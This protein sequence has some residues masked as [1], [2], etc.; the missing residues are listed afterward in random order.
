MCEFTCDAHILV[1]LAVSETFTLDTS[2]LLLYI[3]IIG[4]FKADLFRYCVLLIKGGVYS[5]MDVFLTSNLDEV[6]TGDIGFITP[7]DEVRAIYISFALFF[8]IIFCIFLLFW[9]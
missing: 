5:D 7:V 9:K 8:H 2:T 3:R 4:A 1:C 6:I